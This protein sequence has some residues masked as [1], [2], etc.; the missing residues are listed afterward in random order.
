MDH[1]LIT[2]ETGHQACW[3]ATNMGSVL[4]KEL[5]KITTLQVFKHSPLNGQYGCNARQAVDVQTRHA[6]KR[7]SETV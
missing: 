5:W 7:I 4:I 6:I 3:K 1:Q 2:E